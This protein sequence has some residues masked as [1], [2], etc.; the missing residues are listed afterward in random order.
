ME[1][2]MLNGNAVT[3]PNGAMASRNNIPAAQDNFTMIPLASKPM[4]IINWPAVL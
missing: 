2:V 3:V 4:P 1:A